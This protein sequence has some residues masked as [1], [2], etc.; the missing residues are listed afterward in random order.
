MARK[1][2]TVTDAV[3]KLHNSLAVAH[4]VAFSHDASSSRDI[5]LAEGIISVGGVG[6][7][8]SGAA[9]NGY[10]TNE[11]DPAKVRIVTYGVKAVLRKDI[12]RLIDEGNAAV[13]SDSIA[14]AY[15]VME[16]F[17]KDLAGNFLSYSGKHIP[18]DKRFQEKAKK[19][20]AKNTPPYFKEVAKA[21]AR[22]NCDGLYKLFFKH[23]DGLEERV[24]TYHRGDLH[25]SHRAVEAIRHLKTHEFGRYIPAKIKKCPTGAQHIVKACVRNS[26]IHK[27]DWILPTFKQAQD[28][29]I[30]EAEYGQI[31]YQSVSEELGMKIDYLPG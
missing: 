1:K 12:L 7:L 30:R 3:K 5:K 11:S 24:R 21:M 6:A 19:S 4:F 29:L 22:Q 28:F 25:D 13:Q 26:I 27:T 8:I 2:N 9:F 23:V 14:T 20:F 18:I 17:I 15:E 31:L 16:T 10:D